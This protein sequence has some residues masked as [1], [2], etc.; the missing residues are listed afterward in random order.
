MRRLLLGVAFLVIVSLALIW[1]GTNKRNQLRPYEE[2]VREKGDGKHPGT[3]DTAQLPPS[4]QTR[5]TSANPSEAATQNGPAFQLSPARPQERRSSEQVQQA[6][7]TSYRLVG[8]ASTARI[9]DAAGNTILKSGPESGIYISGCRPS[10][11]GKVIYVD[12]AESPDFL[13]DPATGER[14]DLPLYPDSGNETMGVLESWHWLDDDT[15]IARAFEWKA[16]GDS[17]ASPRQDEANIART[18]LYVYRVLQRQT[19]EVAVPKLRVAT[20]EIDRTRPG[21]VHLFNSTVGEDGDLGWFEV[22][23]Q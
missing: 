4:A 11:S 12:S 16:A 13:L 10:P 1:R 22:R 23:G 21:A 8:N 9:V 3:T 18:R 6:G 19:F 20:F 15:L 2:R 14:T 17:N 5:Q 7:N